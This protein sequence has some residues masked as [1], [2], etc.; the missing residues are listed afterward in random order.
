[1]DDAFRDLRQTFEDDINVSYGTSHPFYSLKIVD[2]L[3]KKCAS[4]ELSIDQ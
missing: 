3:I 4:Y 2:F 1:M